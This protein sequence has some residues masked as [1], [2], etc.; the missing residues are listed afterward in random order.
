MLFVDRFQTLSCKPSTNQ[1][2]NQPINQVCVNLVHHTNANG[3]TGN[4]F[5]TLDA[6]QEVLEANSIL[7]QQSQPN[8][9]HGNELHDNA[10]QPTADCHTR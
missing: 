2:T 7:L 1:S 5:T 9:D 6:L 4:S 3:G 10:T 8:I